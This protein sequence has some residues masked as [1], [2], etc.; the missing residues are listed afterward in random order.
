L[1]LRERLV[2]RDGHQLMSGHTVFSA[3]SSAAFLQSVRAT[4]FW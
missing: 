2:T 4:A 1:N 3:T